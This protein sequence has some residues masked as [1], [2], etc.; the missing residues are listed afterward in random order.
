MNLKAAIFHTGTQFGKKTLI[1]YTVSLA[2]QNQYLPLQLP[3]FCIVQVSESD[4]FRF[5]GSQ[6]T[7]KP[8]F[9]LSVP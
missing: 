8:G 2:K 6:S 3:A 9:P 5:L 1:S 7:N 4:S